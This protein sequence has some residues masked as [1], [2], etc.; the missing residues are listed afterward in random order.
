MCTGREET[1]PYQ[2]NTGKTPTFLI[3]G[4]FSE[5]SFTVCVWRAADI[6]LEWGIRASVQ[7][8]VHDVQGMTEESV[9]IPVPCSRVSVNWSSKLCRC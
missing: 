6:V 5:Q 4:L 7:H 1:S 9:L 3:P 8:D 2:W